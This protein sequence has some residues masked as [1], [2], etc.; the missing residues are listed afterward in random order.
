[1]ILPSTIIRD[2]NRGPNQSRYVATNMG[3]RSRPIPSMAAHRRTIPMHGRPAVGYQLEGTNYYALDGIF[4]KI[5]K[6]IGKVA[7][8]AVKVVGKVAKIALPVAAG[9]IGVKFAAPIIGKGITAI[10][11]KGVKIPQVQIAP[12][13]GVPGDPGIYQQ[14]VQYNPPQAPYGPQ[15]FAPAAPATYSSAS[16]PAATYDDASTA[17][18]TLP[19]GT[20]PPWVIPVAIG[21]AALLAVNMMQPRRGRA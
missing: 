16:A 5:G 19:S 18:P 3:R 7:K 1:M 21:G 13:P 15:V 9:V 11:H 10:F 2:R 6:A 20:M 12:N 8:G 4:S 14:P 17:T